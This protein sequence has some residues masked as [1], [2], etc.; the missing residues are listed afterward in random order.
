MAF[1]TDIGPCVIWRRLWTASVFK[2]LL[3]FC[4]TELWQP[5]RWSSLHHRFW[6][7]PLHRNGSQGALH[8]RLLSLLERQIQVSTKQNSVEAVCQ[9]KHTFQLLLLAPARKVI[10][11]AWQK[12]N[13]DVDGLTEVFLT[14]P[15][16]FCFVST[17]FWIDIN[18]W[19]ISW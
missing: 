17:S 7:P 2:N 8:G 5:H 9:V 1:I 4:T 10:L 16:A 3:L 11:Y 19:H 13:Q 6:R 15:W 14:V 12:L 18:L